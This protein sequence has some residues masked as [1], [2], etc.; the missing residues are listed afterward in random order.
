MLIRGDFS[1][2]IFPGS[3]RW[4]N[5]SFSGFYPAPNVA[6]SGHNSTAV[7]TPQKL[8]NLAAFIQNLADRSGNR[9]NPDP[10]L[11]YFPGAHPVNRYA[12]FSLFSILP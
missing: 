12:F 7:K 11:E 5:S 4:Y 2:V 8:R 6:V 9:A 1:R 10:I 3:C